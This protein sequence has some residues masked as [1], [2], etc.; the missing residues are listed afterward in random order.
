MK[1]AV[2]GGKENPVVYS[3]SL[4][5]QKL[6]FVDVILKTLPSKKEKEKE[7]FL[8]KSFLKN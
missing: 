5:L 3:L 1:W 7:K 6:W 4:S 8:I 2:I